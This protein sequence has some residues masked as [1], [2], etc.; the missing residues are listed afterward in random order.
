M[1]H[2]K[3]LDWRELPAALNAIEKASVGAT[4][5]PLTG[6]LRFLALT[7]TRS[8]E[9]RGMTWAEVDGAVWEIPASRTKMQRAHRVPLSKPALAILDAARQNADASGRVFSTVTGRQIHDSSF[10]KLFRVNGI[11]ATAHGMRSAFRT[12]ASERG[13]DRQ[14]SEFALGHV[15]GSAAELAYLRGDLFE[16]RAGLMEDWGNCFA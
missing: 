4:T 6:A 7:A 3:A 1:K 9:V 14:V 5:E 13:H 15:E 11:D 12:W 16:R 2:H 8:G 10:S